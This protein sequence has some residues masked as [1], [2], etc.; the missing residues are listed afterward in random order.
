MS[1]QREFFRRAA[2]VTV[3]FAARESGRV[4]AQQRTAK[5]PTSRA[6]TLMADFGL[7]YPIFAP[8]WEAA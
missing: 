7:K 8:G 5:I 1:D 4:F 6:A 2:A 3:G